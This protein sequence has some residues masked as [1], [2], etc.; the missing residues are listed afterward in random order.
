MVQ[1]FVH[2]YR[3]QCD[4]S[5]KVSFYVNERKVKVTRFYFICEYLLL[6]VLFLVC[7]VFCFDGFNFVLPRRSD[8]DSQMDGGDL[9]GPLSVLA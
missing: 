7:C 3:L 6:G 9:H 4:R 5:I 2:I 1:T 8:S